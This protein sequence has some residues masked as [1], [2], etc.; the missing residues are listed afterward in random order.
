MLETLTANV[1]SHFSEI[2][3]DV[4]KSEADCKAGNFKQGGMDAADVIT[5]M[6]GAV[7]SL[8]ESEEILKKAH[9]QRSYHM[10]H[11]MKLFQQ[12]R[13]GE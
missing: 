11:F 6:L 2:T 12:P 7:P 10:H 13:W 5:Q 1:M 3:G 4:S 9:L 8:E